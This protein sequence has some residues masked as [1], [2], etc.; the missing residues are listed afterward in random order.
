MD[1]DDFYKAGGVFT[2][3]SQLE[4]VYTIP[5]VILGTKERFSFSILNKIGEARPIYMA[6]RRVS[7]ISAPSS[8]LG[9]FFK[10]L[11]E[12]PVPRFEQLILYATDAQV[13]QH[14]SN[15]PKLP[16]RLLLN[17]PGTPINLDRKGTQLV[18]CRSCNAE[19]SRRGGILARCPAC[20]AMP[21]VAKEGTPRVIELFFDY[22]G[23]NSYNKYYEGQLSVKFATEKHVEDEK[24]GLMYIDGREAALFFQNYASH[25]P[26]GVFGPFTMAF[27]FNNNYQANIFDPPIVVE[28]H[29]QGGKNSPILPITELFPRS[30]IDGAGKLEW[31][32]AHVL[33]EDESGF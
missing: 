19:V 25:C 16:L 18:H 9:D 20:G 11:K 17:Q 22:D 30:L 7:A 23:E 2:G 4:N 33:P 8:S 28:L 26:N 13:K 27:D 15:K 3:T 6:G 1:I 10:V 21:F 12:G 24:G 32:P 29:P 31:R 5:R 14:D